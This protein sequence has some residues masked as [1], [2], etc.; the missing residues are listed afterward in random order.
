MRLYYQKK[1]YSA[2]YVL[3]FKGKQSEFSDV[4]YRHGLDILLFMNN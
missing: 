1:K 3:Y 4:Y 2:Y